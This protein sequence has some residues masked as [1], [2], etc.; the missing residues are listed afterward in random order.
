MKG[1]NI[2]KRRLPKSKRIIKGIHYTALIGPLVGDVAVNGLKVHMI[3]P[4]CREIELKIKNKNNENR[5]KS[6]KKKSCFKPKKY[7][8]ER[9][10]VERKEDRLLNEKEVLIN[11]KVKVRRDWVKKGENEYAYNVWD[12]ELRE[13]LG[14]TPWESYMC[15]K[16]DYKCTFCS[17]ITIRRYNLHRHMQTIHKW[18]KK[19]VIT[20]GKEKQSSAK[21]IIKRDDYECPHCN[22][23]T[24][25][26]NNLKTHMKKLHKITEEI[27]FLKRCPYCP[28]NTNNTETIKSHILK[29]HYKREVNTKKKYFFMQLQEYMN[30]KQS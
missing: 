26:T 18:K 9:H 28:F 16:R 4:I 17:Y 25:R 23:E 8:I 30:M 10:I 12:E 24:N 5:L 7:Y 13:N 2:N 21:K 3:S 15:P 19:S 6:N 22:F 27:I 11:K 14:I 1:K 20:S 29:F